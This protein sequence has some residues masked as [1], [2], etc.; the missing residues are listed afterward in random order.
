LIWEKVWS[1]RTGALGV[2]EQQWEDGEMVKMDLPY[3]SRFARNNMISA[4]KPTTQ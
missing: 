1:D 4:A 3:Y 2:E